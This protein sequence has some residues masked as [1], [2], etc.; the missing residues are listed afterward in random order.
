MMMYDRLVTYK[1]QLKSTHV[2]LRHTGQNQLTPLG[3]WVYDLRAFYRDGKLLKKRMD[4]LNSIDFEWEEK[5][6]F[7]TE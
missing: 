5:N 1:K 3:K 6:R 7:C 2:P 4:R